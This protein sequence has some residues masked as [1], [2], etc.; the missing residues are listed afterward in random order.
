[1]DP[2]VQAKLNDLIRRWRPP[3]PKV[4]ELGATTETAASFA[5]AM[6][7]L[8]YTGVDLSP[9][10]E[11][12]NAGVV[13]GDA[14]TMPEFADGSVDAVV[15][16]SMLEHN[17]RFWLALGEIRRIL[18]NDGLFFVGVPGYAS[19]MSKVA[20]LAR[21]TR[22]GLNRRGMRWLGKVVG[23]AVATRTYPM[24]LPPHDFYRFSP[25][26][27]QEV[28]LEGFELLEFTSVLSPPHLIA[29]GRRL[30]DG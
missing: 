5:P 25:S 3:G 13:V 18:R 28:I 26:A 15:T 22:N 6:E 8:E 1:V 10:V 9:S 24:H 30:E 11:D 7:G 12:R 20:R 23:A 19:E 29:V 27:V 2:N 17:P 4:V 16:S 21:V 14:N